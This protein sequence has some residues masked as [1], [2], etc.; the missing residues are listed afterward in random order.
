MGK[1]IYYP[2]GQLA[3]SADGTVYTPGGE[4]ID[5]RHTEH[6]FPVITEH[7]KDNIVQ[8]RNL[9]SDPYNPYGQVI[10]IGEIDEQDRA[11]G[12]W[13]CLAAGNI[14]TW[15]DVWFH[16]GSQIATGT[17]D[18]DIHLLR[19]V[20]KHNLQRDH[21]T[22][23]DTLVQE[24]E[25][26]A[27][28]YEQ[29]RLTILEQLAEDAK[30]AE[31]EM[32][33]IAVRDGV[34]GLPAPYTPAFDPSIC[35]IGQ[36]VEGKGIYIGTQKFKNKDGLKQIFDLYAAPKDLKWDSVNGHHMAAKY[37]RSVQELNQRKKLFGHD[38]EC[39]QTEKEL[40][41]AIAN[42]TYNGGWFIPT[43]NILEENIYP[44]IEKGDLEDTFWLKSSKNTSYFNRNTNF[45]PDKYWSCTQA[46]AFIQ[47][48]MYNVRLSNG[49][50]DCGGFD[51]KSQQISIRPV[52]A[53]PR[54]M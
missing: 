10:A 48:H 37:N 14:R 35:E 33:N 17:P 23:A 53:E 40:K 41:K 49:Q 34:T 9:V 54:P 16:E 51:E 50:R 28:K 12:A 22:T 11:H 15:N 21:F 5:K 45:T 2:H 6:V 26:A 42:G 25:D 20:M 39:F 52:R 32:R 36:M 13:T 27:T 19:E 3:I 24:A 29:E 31:I 4:K 30:Q 43:L 47:P 8:Y 44:N 18:Q 1:D 46:F 7:V 38:G